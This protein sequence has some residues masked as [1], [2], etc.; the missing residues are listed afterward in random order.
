MSW[1]CGISSD[2]GHLLLVEWPQKGAGSLPPPDLEL[3]FEF[4]ASGR[5]ARL[6]RRHRARE[7]L[8]C[9]TCETTLD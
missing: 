2:A 3:S 5:R 7:S 8:G 6:A 1:G 4:A 9:V